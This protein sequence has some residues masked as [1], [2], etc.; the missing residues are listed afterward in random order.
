MVPSYADAWEAYQI[1]VDCI[2]AICEYLNRMIENKIN[3]PPGDEVKKELE[4]I[5]KLKVSSV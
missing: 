5:I 4:E 1:S 3:V 2:D